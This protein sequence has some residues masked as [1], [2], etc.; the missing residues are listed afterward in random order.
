[1]K[2]AHEN[3]ALIAVVLRIWIHFNPDPDPGPDKEPKVTTYKIGKK[4]Q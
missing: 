2:N 4:F 1:M 3:I